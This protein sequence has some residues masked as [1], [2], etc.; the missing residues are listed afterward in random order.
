MYN[1]GWDVLANSNRRTLRPHQ[2]CLPPV[3]ASS[4]R[5]EYFELRSVTCDPE[6]RFP[7]GKERMLKSLR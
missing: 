1:C 6:S 3:N 5:T 7:A 2:A 4:G